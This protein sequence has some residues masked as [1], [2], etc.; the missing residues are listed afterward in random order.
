[1]SHEKTLASRFPARKQNLLRI[2]S[3]QKKLLFLWVSW[4]CQY[5]FGVSRRAAQGRIELIIVLSAVSR[6]VV[7]VVVVVVVVVMVVVL[8]VVVVVVVVVSPL[9]CLQPAALTHSGFGAVPGGI[10][11]HLGYLLLIPPQS[12]N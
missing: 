9:N 12:L 7:G 1:M 10:D 11:N 2:R 4:L 8:V 3:F 6:V 5:K